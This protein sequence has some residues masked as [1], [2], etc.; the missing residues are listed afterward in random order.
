[1]D[2]LFGEAVAKKASG[3]GLRFE[4]GRTT[5]EGSV[6]GVVAGAWVSSRIEASRKTGV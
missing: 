3:S 6:V 2:D 4:K 5:M 1:M